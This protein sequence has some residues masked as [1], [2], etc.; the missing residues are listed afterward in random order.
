MKDEFKPKLLTA[1]EAAEYL[2]TPL[3]TLTYWRATGKGP[4]TVK[5]GR[6]ILYHLADLDAYIARCRRVQS[7]NQ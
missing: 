3:K 7:L 2:R 4:A 6:G 5:M 1:A